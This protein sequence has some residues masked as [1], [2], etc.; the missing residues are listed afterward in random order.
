MNKKIQMLSVLIIINILSSI[1]LS[2]FKYNIKAVYQ[3]VSSDIDSINT[4]KYPGIKEKIQDLKA[5]H[6]NWNFKI[7]YTG[8]SWEE[9]IANEYIGHGS[10]NDYKDENF[11]PRNMVPKSYNGPWVCG[12]CGDRTYDT[13]SWKCASTD[14][15]KYMMDTR[16]LLTYSDVFQF[17]ELSYDE[18]KGYSR[19][20]VKQMVSGSFLDNDSYINTIMD[21]CKKYNANPYYIVARILQEQRK[22]GTTLTKGQGYN[23]Q[24]VGLYNV[25]NIGATGRG[26][27]VIINGFKRAEKEKW[28]SMELSLDGGIK[29][30]SRKYIAVGQNTLYFQKFDVENSDGKL[31]WHQ[32]M[33]NIFA[34]QSEAKRLRE[35]FE[36]I[37][38]ID[39]QYTFIIPVYENMPNNTSPKPGTTNEPDEKTDLVRV[40][41][42]RSIK[43]R[44]EPNGNK[45]I[46]YLYKDEVVTRIQ[47][48]TSKVNG[49]YW[50]K[51]LK[52]NGTTGYVARCTYDYESNYKEYLIPIGENTNN[53]PEENENNNNNNTNE[54][55]STEMG[56]IDGNNIVDAM[57]MYIMIQHILEKEILTGERFTKADMDNNGKI[58]A[59]DMYILIQKIINN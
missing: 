11:S 1:L 43:I 21:S 45:I 54:N 25:F 41:V 3:T 27:Q 35:T 53:P 8:I 47:K 14:T 49:T 15:I 34:A 30:I 4:S 19:D 36:S 18:S 24:Y 26:D 38:A 6:P 9:A 50:D 39:Y 51:I 28:T 16:G 40:N 22:E 5:Q 20:V 29:E 57:D 33:Q 59:M 48:A 7:L 44:N 37:N 42:D 12:Y 10:Q 31:Y 55:P 56:D 58:D 32:Y 52:D 23:G 2:F 17:F 13:G 46:G